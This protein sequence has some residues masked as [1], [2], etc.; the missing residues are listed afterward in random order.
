MVF[1]CLI[2]GVNSNVDIHFT[3]IRKLFSKKNFQHKT[4]HQNF[5]LPVF[6][7]N[8]TGF[9]MTLKFSFEIINE[10]QKFIEFVKDIDPQIQRKSKFTV[11][12]EQLLKPYQDE[13]REKSE[14]VIRQKK[15]SEFFKKP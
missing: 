9:F 2:M 5:I 12:I 8:L 6:I 1:Y 3:L 13:A 10:G 4:L 7:E 11:G 14:K 15:I